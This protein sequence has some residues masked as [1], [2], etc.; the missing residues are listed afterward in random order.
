MFLRSR[1]WFLRRLILTDILRNVAARS[2]VLVV[3]GVPVT[4]A[5]MSRDVAVTSLAPLHGASQRVGDV[6]A[7]VDEV[8]VVGEQSTAEK[9]SN[10]TAAATFTQHA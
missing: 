6:I 9:P 3:G 4:S 7:A 8:T 5:V 10:A 2:S 1:T